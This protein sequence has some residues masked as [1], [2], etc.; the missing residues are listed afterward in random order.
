MFAFLSS[1]SCCWS[2]KS[3]GLVS[4]DGCPC[5]RQSRLS[6][7]TQLSWT[8]VV[9]SPQRRRQ[10]NAGA[11]QEGS[12]STLPGVRPCSL[13]YC[14]CNLRMTTHSLSFIVLSSMQSRLE[15]LFHR[16]VVK[17]NCINTFKATECLLCRIHLDVGFSYYSDL[18][19]PSLSKHFLMSAM[20][21]KGLREAER[22]QIKP[23][24]SSNSGKQ[25][26]EQSHDGGI[27]VFA[28]A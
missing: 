9:T 15:S 12:A 4:P 22:D 6:F 5:D 26:N 16:E 27:N 17:I 18:H 11:K 19:N 14:P 28:E 3:S 2:E 8:A 10:H 23:L 7:L 21:S 13:P 1:L 20:L 25:I 24:L